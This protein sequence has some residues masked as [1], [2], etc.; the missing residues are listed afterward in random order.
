MPLSTLVQQASATSTAATV[1]CP[2][3]NA[4]DLIILFDRASGTS[5]AKVI[6]T[7]FTEI[8]DATSPVGRGVVSYKIA[9]GSEG[10]TSLTGM[11]STAESKCLLTFRADGAIASV[12][13]SVWGTVVTTGNPVA[14]NVTASGASVPLIIFGAYAIL[15]GTIDPRIFTVGGLAAKDGEITA[16]STHYLAW[17]IYTSSPQNAVIDMDDEGTNI[18]LSGYVTVDGTGGGGG[19]GIIRPT[20]AGLLESR[21]LERVRLARSGGRHGPEII[22]GKRK[23]A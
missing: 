13:F 21:L 8:A 2:A 9:T 16:A 4:G 22:A 14:Q 15:T 23:A 6:P 17:K 12:A 10:G 20:G 11:D 5:P 7:D 18:L 3:V 19:G 1:V